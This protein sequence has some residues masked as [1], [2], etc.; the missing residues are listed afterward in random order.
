MFLPKINTRANVTENNT[1]NCDRTG[2]QAVFDAFPCS[3]RLTKDA[4]PLLAASC[5]AAMAME[6]CLSWRLVTH[7]RCCQGQVSRVFPL[8]LLK[9]WAGGAVTL[10]WDNV[11]CQESADHSQNKMYVSGWIKWADRRSSQASMHMGRQVHTHTIIKANKCTPH[12]WITNS[13]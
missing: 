10:A 2:A 7:Q 11:S 6:T 13:D 9:L 4:E 8:E 3:K 1:A 5:L 12:G